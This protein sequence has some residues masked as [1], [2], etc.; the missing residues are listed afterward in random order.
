MLPNREINVEK[1][2]SEFAKVFETELE[3]L[4]ATTGNE[5]TPDGRDAQRPQYLITD[6][7]W[8]TL[9]TESLK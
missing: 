3:K 2:K 7:A 1:D 8:K 4:E 5:Q 6:E 9:N